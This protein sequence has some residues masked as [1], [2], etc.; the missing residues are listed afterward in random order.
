M[1]AC[2]CVRVLTCLF[3]LKV[4]VR[5]RARILV[6]VRV[7][8]C[9]IMGICVCVCG[10]VFMGICVC[11][12]GCVIMGI[13]VCVCGCVIMGILSVCE[14]AWAPALCVRVRHVL[15][16]VSLTCVCVCGAVDNNPEYPG[17]HGCVCRRR[18]HAAPRRN[19]TVLTT[20]GN[21]PDTVSCLL[22]PRE[23]SVD[24]PLEVV[25]QH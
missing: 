17:G 5:A 12:C 23:A 19:V 21:G 8:G 20:W 2:L 7:C 4:C 11:V 1:F 9:L 3:N 13:C 22:E 25:T 14:R 10:C 18:A 16:M 6:H 15:G 24:S